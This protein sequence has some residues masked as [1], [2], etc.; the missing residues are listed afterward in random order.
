[1]TWLRWWR[2]I[3]GKPTRRQLQDQVR[4]LTAELDRL[5]RERNDLAVQLERTGR[6]LEAVRQLAAD[7]RAERDRVR[8]VVHNSG[9]L[10]DAA[11]L[12]R[13]RQLLMG[14]RRDG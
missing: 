8:A 1:M 5:G 7:L 2:P 14:G 4:R 11:V 3:D 9:G 10:A 6:R 13:V 12:D